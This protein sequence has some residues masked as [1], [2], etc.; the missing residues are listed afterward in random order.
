MRAA[1][2]YGHRAGCLDCVKRDLA[3]MCYGV[4]LIGWDT[5]GTE[6]FRSI[7]RSYYR[8]AA[9]CLLVYDV[10]SR[11]SEHFL[12]THS[13]PWIHTL[14]TFR[15]LLLRHPFTSSSLFAFVSTIIGTENP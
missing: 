1:S 11:Q 2:Q 7:T 14:L 6:S 15:V 12:L 10:T 3:Y 5:A 4:L 8:G 9:G 13:F